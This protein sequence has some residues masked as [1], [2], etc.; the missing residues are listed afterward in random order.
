MLLLTLVGE[1]PIPNLLPLWQFQYLDSVQFVATN[2]TLPFVSRMTAAM[3]SDPLLRRVQVFEPLVLD[4]YNTGSARAAIAQAIVKHQAEGREML[5]NLTGGTKMMSIACLQ[6]AY[7]SGV[8]LL[9]VSTQENQHIF[10]GSDGAEQ[11]RTP[12]QVCISVDQYMAAHGIETCDNPSF[13][14]NYRS[15]STPPPKEGDE[16]EL[17]VEEAA[18]NSGYFDDVGRS[19]YIRRQTKNGHVI[20]ELDIVVTRNG[21]MAVASCKTGNIEN[22]HI[23][24]LFSLSS[25]ES[26]GIYCG[27]VLVSSMPSLKDGV[28]YRSLSMGIHL[29]YGDEVAK[30]AEHLKISLR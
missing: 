8:R 24:E 14:P 2:T 22:E 11:E 3:I 4:A 26:A 7:G 12:I 16:L 29:V 23:Y 6:A 5:C 1:Q 15:Y 17:Q 13:D 21:R 20:N 30:V 9:Y 19:L 18:R 25:R 27:K 10:L 28:R